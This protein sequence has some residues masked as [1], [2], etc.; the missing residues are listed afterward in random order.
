MH[1]LASHAAHLAKLTVHKDYLPRAGALMKVVNV[2]MKRLF[3][4]LK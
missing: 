4:R 2:Y 1:N 3:V